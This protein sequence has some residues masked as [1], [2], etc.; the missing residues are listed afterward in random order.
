MKKIFLLSVGLLAASATFAQTTMTGKDARIGLKAGVNLAQIHFSGSQESLNKYTTNNVG[1][2]ITAYGDFG[3]G[4]NFFIQPG[5]SLQNKGTKLEGAAGFGGTA[6][7]GNSTVNVMAI[8]IP[9]NA[10]LRIP[11][12]DAGAF[13]ISAGPYVGFNIDGKT[14]TE[15]NTAGT[16]SKSE[17]DLKFGSST[18]DDIAGT[19]FGANVGLGFR[20][21]NGLTLNA[22]YGLGLTNLY[23]KDKTSN[24]NDKAVNRVLG[25]SV[26]FSF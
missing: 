9:I 25:F 20:M 19:D 26:G 7:T 17:S 3:V 4:Q 8:E 18:S 13:Q 11:A 21:N 14:K 16:V 22:N 6:I 24:N 12:G 15:V 2:N 10:V 1:Y 23:P 5:I